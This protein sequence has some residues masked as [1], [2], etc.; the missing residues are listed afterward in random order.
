MD[1]DIDFANRTDLLSKIQHRVAVLENGRPHN[2]GVYF[3][4]VPYDPTTNR[5]TINYKDAEARGYFKIDCLN[6]NIY[7]Q[8]RDAEHLQ[9]LIDTEPVWELLEYPEFVDQVFHINGHSDILIAMKPKSLIELAAVLAMIR[10]AKRHLVGKSWDDVMRE[11]W[12]KPVSDEYYFKKSHAVS[13]AMA[14]M[15][16]MNLLCETTD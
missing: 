7:Q 12:I 4:E 8:V 11:V 9:R 10:P 14:V 16:H 15:V 1:I 2:S 13:Y 3:T 6:V 5:A